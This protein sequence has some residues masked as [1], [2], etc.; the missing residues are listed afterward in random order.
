MKVNTNK[1]RFAKNQTRSIHFLLDMKNY[2]QLMPRIQNRLKFTNP[3]KGFY[4]WCW[5][6][7]KGW[8]AFERDS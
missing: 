5:R 8:N 2:E 1:V 7:T 3:G 4:G 6:F